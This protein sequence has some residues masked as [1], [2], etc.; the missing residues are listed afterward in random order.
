MSLTSPNEAGVQLS[1][2]AERYNSSLVA[3]RAALKL[4]VSTESEFDLSRAASYYRDA[5]K[6]CLDAVFYY[7]ISTDGLAPTTHEAYPFLVLAYGHCL[8]KRVENGSLQIMDSVDRALDSAQET[9]TKQPMPPEDKVRA[10]IVL[11]GDFLTS[12][13]DL[14]KAESALSVVR[15]SIGSVDETMSEVIQLYREGQDHP[16]STAQGLASQAVLEL[17]DDRLLLAA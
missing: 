17:V 8:S 13:D 1:H 5:G 14:A 15:H 9:F 10:G 16:L 3:C 12:Q 2:E 4:A 11:A 7:P 6:R